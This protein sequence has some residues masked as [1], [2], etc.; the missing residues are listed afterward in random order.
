MPT[1]CLWH[2]PLA[3]GKWYPPLASGTHHS[4]L[5]PFA[6]AAHKFSSATFGFGAHCLPPVPT[7]S[8][9]CP[10][11]TSATCHSLL[12][13]YASAAHHLPL[14]PSALVPAICLCHPP[15]AS[16]HGSFAAATH[17][18]PPPPAPRLLRPPC[19]S[20]AQH[21]RPPGA[22]SNAVHL[23]LASGNHHSRLAPITRFRCHS[24][25]LPT[26]LPLPRSA[27]VSSS[28]HQ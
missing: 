13:P 8:V 3:F 2:P 1:I 11:F 28:A 21:S 23:P 24:R 7:S 10:P 22:F 16:C 9:C 27:L 18:L 26:N 14:P 5:L 20:G 17:E 19:V 25:P 6:S 12:W 4:I 15:F